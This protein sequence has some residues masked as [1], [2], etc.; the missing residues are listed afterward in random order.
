MSVSEL[1][2]IDHPRQ[3]TSDLTELRQA[4][5]ASIS[6]HDVRSDQLKA[7][8]LVKCSERAR[9]I[10]DCGMSTI[11]L[12]EAQANLAELVHHLAPGEEVTITE[13]DRPVARLIP[14]PKIRQRPRRPRQPVT[15][16]A[17]GR[18]VC[19]GCSLSPMTSRNRWTI[20][21]SR[22]SEAPARFVLALRPISPHA[23]EAAQSAGP[24][25]LVVASWNRRRFRGGF[26]ACL[27]LLIGE[28][29]S[30]IA[31]AQHRR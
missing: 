29:D 25:R 14:V 23:E 5:A 13:N 2:V 28:D 4:L 22:W 27:F 26:D 17:Q 20:C 6:T 30:L 15:G 24:A 9:T 19:E 7:Y 31:R 1:P 8:Y 11:T 3:F 10:G 16:S 12:Q 21:G 18:T